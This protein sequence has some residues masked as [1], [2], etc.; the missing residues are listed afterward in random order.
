MARIFALVGTARARCATRTRQGARTAPHNPSHVSSLELHGMYKRP[1]GRL[2]HLSPAAASNLDT[3]LSAL[4]QQKETNMPVTQP[5][6]VRLPSTAAMLR[7][8]P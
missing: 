4:V 1:Y 5:T 7:I 6:A 2:S 3:Q 8:G